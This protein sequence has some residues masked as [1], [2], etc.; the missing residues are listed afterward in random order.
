MDKTTEHWRIKS[1]KCSVCNYGSQVKF[2]DKIKY[3]QQTLSCI[4]ESGG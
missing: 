3:Y 2:I 1:N 4:A